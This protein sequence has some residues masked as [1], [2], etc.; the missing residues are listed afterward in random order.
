MEI[1]WKKN[2][3]LFLIGQALSFFG[4]AVVQYAI[5]W[6]IKAKTLGAA[7]AKKLGRGLVPRTPFIK[8]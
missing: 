4:T 8:I 3:A 2:T 7:P 6:H 1:N 5:L